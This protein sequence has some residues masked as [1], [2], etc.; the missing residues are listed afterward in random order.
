[1]NLDDLRK[2]APD[3]ASNAAFHS[4]ANLLSLFDHKA[5]GLDWPSIGAPLDDRN[6]LR[7]MFADFV[8]ANPTAPAEALFRFAHGRRIHSYPVDDYAQL[9]TG[10]RLAYET[11]VVCLLA[12]DGGIGREVAQLMTAQQAARGTV[13]AAALLEDPEDTILEPLPD[14]LATDP[15]KAL[16]VIEPPSVEPPAAPQ[17][18]PADGADPAI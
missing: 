6:F 13:L 1:M 16:K 3:L 17:Q 9:E 8:R 10:Y 14:P 2:L 4:A 12:A 5:Q 7:Q 18:P 15:H 11:F